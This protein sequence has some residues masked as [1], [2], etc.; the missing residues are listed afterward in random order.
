M[1]WQQVVY[2]KIKSLGGIQEQVTGQNLMFAK[3]LPQ[4]AAVQSKLSNLNCYSNVFSLHW[5]VALSF[6][7]SRSAYCLYAY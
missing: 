2:N 4:T 6:K 5:S 1:C 3:P 7:L